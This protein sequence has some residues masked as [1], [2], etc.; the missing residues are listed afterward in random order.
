MLVVARFRLKFKSL[1]PRRN[2]EIYLLGC[3]LPWKF[4]IKLRS[5][6]TAFK[7]KGFEFESRRVL[8]LPLL[9]VPALLP[10]GVTFL[11]VGASQ[12]CYARGQKLL[13]WIPSWVARVK[14]ITLRV[15][16]QL[17]W[18]IVCLNSPEYF[19]NIKFRYERLLTIN[20]GNPAM[21]KHLFRA[22]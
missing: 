12:L 17:S 19:F 7:L 22:R 11:L 16:L 2:E 9:C 10:V 18:I 14:R 21:T 3:Q 20:F 15:S 6:L 13:K 5:G 8:F 4:N 1:N